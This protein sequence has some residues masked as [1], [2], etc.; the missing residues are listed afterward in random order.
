[1]FKLL[2]EVLRKRGIDE[3]D[4]KGAVLALRRVRELRNSLKG[5]AAPEKRRELERLAR[6]EFGSFRAQFESLV[7]KANGALDLIVRAL[8]AAEDDQVVKG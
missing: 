3:E 8:T 7:A 4:T 1:V 2:E 5:H 6:K